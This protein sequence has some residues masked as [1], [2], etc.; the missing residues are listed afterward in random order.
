MI[1]NRAKSGNDHWVAQQYLPASLQGQVFYQ[2][3]PQGFEGEISVQVARRREAQLAAMMSGLGTEPIE[4][5][6]YS[7]TD[8]ASERWLQRTLSQ[9]GTQLANVRER[10]FT[11]TQLQ[12]HHVVLDINAGTG[13]L[14]WEAV[15]H[16]PEGGVYACVRNESDA[17]ALREQ[18]ATLDE[19]R[20]PMVVTAKITELPAVLA[21]QALGVNKEH[22]IAIAL[23]QL[24][25][26]YRRIAEERQNI[27]W[28]TVER[29]DSGE[30][31]AKHYHVILHYERIAEEESKFEAM[32]N[33]IM[34]NTVVENAKITVI[35][36]DPSIPIDP[37]TR[38]WD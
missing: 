32:H 29:S 14:T 23:E 38:S 16:V 36:I 37:L 6:T 22:A 10:I 15:R 35:E 33:T 20:R 11:I 9:I 27:D 3:S 12:R 17:Q 28:E 5:L 19:I 7:N 2:P 24:A 30:P 34:G 13:L 8:A 1:Y 18:A 31:I 4:I 21:S 26:E 25:D